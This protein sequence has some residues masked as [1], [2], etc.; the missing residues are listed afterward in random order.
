MSITQECVQV[1]DTD[2]EPRK[3]ARGI[4]VK[5]LAGASAFIAGL[6]TLIN[7]TPAAADCQGSPCCSLASCTMCN[8]RVAHD[9]FYCPTGY[10]RTVW[11]CVSGSS[12]FWCGECSGGT[13]C[14][15]GPFACSIWFNN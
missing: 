6:A 14:W 9:R 8:Y 10:N 11:S 4:G 1:A 12:M 13:S 7:A 15:N 5:A 3:G 2:I